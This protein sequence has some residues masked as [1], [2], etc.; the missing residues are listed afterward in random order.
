M[1]LKYLDNFF[2]LEESRIERN[3]RL[4]YLFKY[5]DCTEHTIMGHIFYINEKL[6]YNNSLVHFINIILDKIEMRSNND[7]SFDLKIEQLDI[8]HIKISIGTN[9]TNIEK[10]DNLLEINITLYDLKN[11]RSTINH[12]LHHIF[13]TS[14]GLIT[15]KIYYKV[16]DLIRITSGK[17]KAFLILYY[18]S[19]PDELNSNIHMFHSQIG[20]NKIKTKDQFLKFLNN[21]TLY[22]IAIKMKN[23]DIMEYWLAIKKEGNNKL[24]IDE[25]NINNLYD[26]IKKVQDEII[27]AGDTYIKKLSKSFI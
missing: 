23:F 4:K 16:N 13:M 21:N 10:I 7:I 25:L 18:L 11:I 20:E 15:N 17:T 14:K 2:H 22:N 3:N 24:L 9:E 1:K 5:G 6:G 27:S 12:E 19:F 8:E 26:F